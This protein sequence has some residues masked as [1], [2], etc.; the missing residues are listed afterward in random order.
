MRRNSSPPLLFRTLTKQGDPPT[1]LTT[2]REIVETSAARL[3]N[4]RA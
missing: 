2:V 4:E 1:T 3:L